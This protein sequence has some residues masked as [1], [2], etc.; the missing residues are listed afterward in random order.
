MDGGDTRIAAASLESASWPARATGPGKKPGRR[1]ALAG[2]QGRPYA[3]YGDAPRTRIGWS[4]APDWPRIRLAEQLGLTP[5]FAWLAAA[6]RL[7][8]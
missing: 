2:L 6:S 7:P 8:R 3:M 1:A 4:A 5:R